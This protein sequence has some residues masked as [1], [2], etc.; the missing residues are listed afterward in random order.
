M[1]EFCS[2]IARGLASFFNPSNE[3]S[4]TSFPFSLWP[5]RH[6]GKAGRG[7]IASPVDG[8]GTPRRAKISRRG[9]SPKSGG[10]SAVGPEPPLAFGD[11]RMAMLNSFMRY[12]Q[13]YHPG[14]KTAENSV[15]P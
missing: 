8:R 5:V 3:A 7:G 4:K 15:C 11:A 12:D 6:R 13:V 10:I 2:K 9:S 1:V 14:G